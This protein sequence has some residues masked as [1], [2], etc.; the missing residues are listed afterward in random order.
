MV[1]TPTGESQQSIACRRESIQVL[2][3][4]TSATETKRTQ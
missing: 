4:E 3:T 1:Q 2:G